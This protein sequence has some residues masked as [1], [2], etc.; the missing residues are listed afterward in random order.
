MLDC[1]YV[2]LYTLLCIAVCA[3]VKLSLIRIKASIEC[4]MQRLSSLKDSSSFTAWQIIMS[5]DLLLLVDANSRHTW[6]F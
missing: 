2:Y 3:N 4:L 5:G 6:I 1:V